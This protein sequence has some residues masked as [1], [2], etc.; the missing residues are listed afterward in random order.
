MQ[1]LFALSFFLPVS[2]TIGRKKNSFYW[3]SSQICAMNSTDRIIHVVCVLT[4][5]NGFLVW[6]TFICDL[7]L[8]IVVRH[9]ARSGSPLERGASVQSGVEAR[10]RSANLKLDWIAERCFRRFRQE[11]GTLNQEISYFLKKEECIV[12]FRY[13]RFDI[14][15]MEPLP[16][17]M[18][19]KLKGL[20]KCSSKFQW[21]D[22][23]S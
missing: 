16:A 2:H 9:G 5:Q 6:N 18:Y 3:I 10:S 4:Y 1:A 13:A 19:K 22:N 17:E 23:V 12:I 15:K 14:N 8:C 11:C 7:C 20:W 21:G